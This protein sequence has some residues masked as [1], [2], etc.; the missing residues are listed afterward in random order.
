MVCVHVWQR[1]M[2]LGPKAPIQYLSVFA[3]VAGP[4]LPLPCSDYHES[5][6]SNFSGFPPNWNSLHVNSINGSCEFA[7]SQLSVA[8]AKALPLTTLHEEGRTG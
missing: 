5:R 8:K 1:V 7:V 3:T 4:F 6:S 2:I